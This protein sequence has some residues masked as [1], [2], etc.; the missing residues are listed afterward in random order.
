MDP[1]TIALIVCA[2]LVVGALAISTVRARR[3]PEHQHSTIEERTRA[4]RIRQGG[5]Y[6]LAARS[7]AANLR[8]G[9]GL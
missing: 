5:D 9:T 2:V 7:I 8:D 6:D 3:K 4:A 1:F